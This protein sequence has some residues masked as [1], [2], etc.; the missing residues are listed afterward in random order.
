MLDQRLSFYWFN[1]YYF[2]IFHIYHILKVINW[3]FD[4]ILTILS[5][6]NN[7]DWRNSKQIFI[8]STKTPNFFWKSYKICSRHV[9]QPDVLGDLLSPP[10]AQGNQMNT[11]CLN[12]L[13]LGCCQPLPDPTRPDILY[14][15]Y[16]QSP[17]AKTFRTC[18]TRHLKP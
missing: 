8:P 12:S 10:Q 16:P 5:K 13:Y 3:W 4:K 15:V 6:N 7:Q 14:R 17:K 11:L 1:I 2:G 9:D 18:T